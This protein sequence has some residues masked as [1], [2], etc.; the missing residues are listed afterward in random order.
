MNKNIYKIGR[1]LSLAVLMAIAL[2]ACEKDDQ[3]NPTFKATSPSFTLNV[4]ANA[5]NN[6]Y[7]LASA[8][9]LTLTCSQ[10]DYNGVPYVVEY[11]VQVALDQSFSSYRELETSFTTAK[12]SADALEINNAMIDLYTE[13]N[14]DVAYPNE[15]RPLYV[16][17]RAALVN[18]A[19]TVFDESYSNIIT[20]PKVLATYI[21]PTLEVP[22]SIYVVGSSIGD[23]VDKGYWS[24]WKPLAPVYGMPGEFYTIIY[25][26]DG[27]SFKWGEAEQD[28]RGYSNVTEFNDQAGAGL[29]E[30]G[31]GNIEVANGGWFTLY[32]VTEVGTNAIK[33]TFNLY[34]ASAYII[35]AV[36]GGEW[37]D[38]DAN[39]QMT[40]PSGDGT[41]E[42]PAF[43]AGGEL[44]AYIKVPGID[45]WRTEF[46]LFSGGLYWRTI[47]IPNNWAEN[48]GEA[49]SVS[50]SAGQKLYVN[51]STNTGE[52]K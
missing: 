10:P 37:T 48:V 26:P 16:R 34:P 5:Q 46:T 12:M 3:S 19:N 27:G 52:V 2:T 13:A 28:W 23:G 42:S 31:D 24:Y 29:S 30:N 22:T 38:S 40:A 50:C 20:L 7:D 43:A 35:G 18:I 51:F 39:W 36:A 1:L 11:H 44:R 45:W 41:W 9:G 21:A 47:D 8:N 14:G 6:T 25:V 17:L 33:Y 32:V 15:A 4:P 49:Y